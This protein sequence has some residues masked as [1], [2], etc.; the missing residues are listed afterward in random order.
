M[1]NPKWHRDEII[2]ALDLYHDPY[3]GTVDSKNPNIIAL[4]ELLNKLPIFM[5]KPDGAKFRNPNGVSLKLSNFMAIDPNHKGKGMKSYSKLDKEVFEE[6]GRDRRKL[7]EMANR[8]KSIVTN[9]F[10]KLQLDQIEND[11]VSELDSVQEGQVLYKL[12]KYRERNNK[13]TKKKKNSILKS[14]GKLACEVC[15][16]DFKEEY[17]ELGFGFIECHHTKPLYTSEDISTTK[18]TDLALVCSNCHRMLHKKI[19]TLSIE[20]LQKLIKKK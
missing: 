4:S 3:R 11:E 2:L 1:K 16:F 10:I 8:I 5:E 12:H 17:G 15:G 18:L 14:K 20:D 9:D 19:S 6:F 7:R 13:I